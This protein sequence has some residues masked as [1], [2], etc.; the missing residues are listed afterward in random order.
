MKPSRII[1][2]DPFKREVRESI[3]DNYSD[4]SKII[5]NIYCLG[6]NIGEDS[7]LVDDEGLFNEDHEFFHVK[8]YPQSLAGYGVV[9]GV[10]YEGETVD[11]KSTVKDVLSKISWVD[12][13]RGQRAAAETLSRGPQITE[14]NSMEELAKAMKWDE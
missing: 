8:G 1:I 10:D 5:G 14:F 6:P 11:A 3:A 7:L 13:V 2:I 4:F 9:S 12:K